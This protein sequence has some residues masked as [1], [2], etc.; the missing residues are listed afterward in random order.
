MS[1]DENLKLINSIRSACESNLQDRFEDY[2]FLYFDNVPLKTFGQEYK[3]E[4][5]EVNFDWIGD[6]KLSYQICEDEDYNN[7]KQVCRFEQECAVRYKFKLNSFVESNLQLKTI[8]FHIKTFEPFGDT[9]RIMVRINELSALEQL[10]KLRLEIK[11]RYQIEN[12]AEVAYENHPTCFGFFAHIL[13]KPRLVIPKE[14]EITHG[15]FCTEIEFCHQEIEECLLSALFHQK[16]LNDLFGKKVISE[17]GRVHLPNLDYSD[18]QY[19]LMIGFGF[20][21]LYSFWDRITFLLANFVPVGFKLE[22]LSFDKYFEKIEN[23]IPNGGS[24]FNSNSPHLN[25]LLSFYNNNYPAIEKYRHRNVHF[26]MRTTSEWQGILSSRFSNNTVVNISDEIELKKLKLEFE[27]L[28]N[29]L[30]EHFNFCK[31]GFVEA[32]KLIDELE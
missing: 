4:L 14:S 8:Q 19:L 10:R 23:K 7:G 2:R 17:Y 28:G 32:L 22:H 25:W 11:H 13:R 9:I 20:D 31:Q 12:I 3:V 24:L 29:L 26:K 5:T 16:N 18:M 21:R 27:G 1:K 15:F 30:L 6:E